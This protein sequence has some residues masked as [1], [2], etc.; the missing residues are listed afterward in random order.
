MKTRRLVQV[1][2]SSSLSASSAHRSSSASSVGSGGQPPGLA[3]RWGGQA[4][5]PLGSGG[6]WAWCPGPG[7]PP[8]WPLWLAWPWGRRPLSRGGRGTTGRPLRRPPI[9]GALHEPPAGPAPA[10]PRG[11][12]RPPLQPRFLPDAGPRKP[13]WPLA[14]PTGTT[15][16]LPPVQAG[17]VTRTSV[18]H[19]CRH[20]PA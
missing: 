3:S 16:S 5:P 14:R 9:N 10:P 6:S 13:G 4:W 12:A 19:H 20:Q 18:H 2:S 15:L 7:W 11:P 8:L 1:S 17:R